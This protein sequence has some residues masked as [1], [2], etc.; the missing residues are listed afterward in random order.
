MPWALTHMIHIIVALAKKRNKKQTSLAIL[1]HF[2]SFTLIS[3]QRH[4]H[5]K[6]LPVVQ[7]AAAPESHTVLLPCRV[8]KSHSCLTWLSMSGSGSSAISLFWFT[9]AEYRPPLLFK[10]KPKL[11]SLALLLPLHPLSM[12]KYFLGTS[13]EGRLWIRWAIGSWKLH[14]QGHA[15]TA[16]REQHEHGHTQLRQ[17]RAPLFAWARNCPQWWCWAQVCNF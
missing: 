5:E 8:D 6:T 10:D 16:T 15:A 3:L 13:R 14:R 4:P 12:L 1:C 7:E 11:R 17:T 2:T 9:R